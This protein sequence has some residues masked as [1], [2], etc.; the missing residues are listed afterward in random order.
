MCHGMWHGHCI[1]CVGVCPHARV[2]YA[3]CITAHVCVYHLHAG[4]CVQVAVHMCGV[5]MHV[6]AHVSGAVRSLAQLPRP[7]LL[8]PGPTETAASEGPAGSPHSESSPAA[9]TPSRAP[10]TLEGCASKRG[11][12]HRACRVFTV[13]HCGCLMHLEKCKEQGSH[14]H[15][16]TQLQEESVAN[17]VVPHSEFPLRPDP[18][19]FVK[20]LTAPR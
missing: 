9:P 2:C 13:S 17:T 18:V 8:V 7:E 11:S 6:C 16:P 19:G 5:Y 20:P 14:S 1:M 3:C 12:V 10:C 4:A 15:I